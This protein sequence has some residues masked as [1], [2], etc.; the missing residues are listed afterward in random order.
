MNELKLIHGSLELLAFSFEQVG[1]QFHSIL[2]ILTWVCLIVFLN[3]FT[4]NLRVRIG[5]KIFFQF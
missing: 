1:Y 2:T 3:T 4:F 5:R